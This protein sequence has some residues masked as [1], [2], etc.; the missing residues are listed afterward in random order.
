MRDIQQTHR[1]LLEGFY[2]VVN[3][4]WTFSLL[5]VAAPFRCHCFFSSGGLFLPPH[6]IFSAVLCMWP[7]NLQQ[8]M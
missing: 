3:I 2:T 1:Q 6:L 8:E 4:Q 5:F 7:S